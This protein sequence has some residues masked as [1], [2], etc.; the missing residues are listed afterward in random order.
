MS[1]RRGFAYGPVTLYGSGFHR[2]PLPCQ[3][4]RGAGPTTPGAALPTAPVWAPARS[5]ATTCAIIIIFSSSGYLDVSVPRVRPPRL[6]AVCRNRFR[7]VSPFGHPR[8]AGH[9]PLTAAFRSLSRPS[10]PPGATGIPHAPFLSFLVSSRAWTARAQRAAASRPHSLLD[11]TIISSLDR[12][13]NSISS[14]RF[15]DS[16]ARAS[17]GEGKRH[18]F[19]FSSRSQ[20]VND[21]I[22]LLSV[23]PGRL[24]LPTS[25]LSV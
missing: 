10:S 20:H 8:V 24:E 18:L 25:T 11:L 21:L 13:L 14:L 19:L 23:V 2:I 15:Q 9:L 7:R 6:S 12:S 16:S 5:L 17:T 4:R 22:S 1:H 3:C